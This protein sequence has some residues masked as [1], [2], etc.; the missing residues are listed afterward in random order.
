M[1]H[2]T[3]HRLRDDHF[4]LF[5]ILPFEH[6]GFVQVKN[7]LDFH[8]LDVLSWRAYCLIQKRLWNFQ[9]GVFLGGTFHF[10]EIFSMP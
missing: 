1:Y 3:V 10:I 8:S 9:A 5:A 6:A 2:L 4:V 7:Q